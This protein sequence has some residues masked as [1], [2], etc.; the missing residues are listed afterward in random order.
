MTKSALYQYTQSTSDG[1]TG[2]E[3][4][5]QCLTT[6]MGSQLNREDTRIRHTDIRRPIQLQVRIHDAPECKG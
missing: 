5:V 6:Y 1:E 4:Q 2:E 3:V